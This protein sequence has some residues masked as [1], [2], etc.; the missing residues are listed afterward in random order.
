[1]FK[2]IHGHNTFLKTIS[3]PPT[4]FG[5]F[6]CLNILIFTLILKRALSAVHYRAAQVKNDIYCFKMMISFLKCFNS[7][8][9]LFALYI[10]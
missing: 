10:P 9:L 3:L 5:N 8:D 6:K 1:M 2:F 4:F 7:P